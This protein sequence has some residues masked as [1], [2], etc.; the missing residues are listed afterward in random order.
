MIASPRAAAP[1][2]ERM[3]DLP[4]SEADERLEVEG[5]ALPEWL[6]GTC[7]FNG[8]AR[9]RR[10]DLAYRHWL[11]GDGAVSSLRIT[12]GERPR[13]RRRFVQSTK[14][15]DE[16]AAGRALFRTFGTAFDGDRLRR[17]LGLESPVNVSVVPFAGHLLAFG[18]QGL[19]WAL[20]P[21]TLET[22]GEHTFNGRLNAVSPLSAHPSIDPE[23][24]EMFNFGISYAARRPLVNLYRFTPDGE[25]AGR[26]RIPLPYPCSMHDFGLSRRWATFYVNPHLLDVTGIIESGQC[27]M[28]S[29]SWQPDLGSRLLVVDRESGEIA[30]DVALELPRA[31]LHHIHSFE[32]DGLLYVDLLELDEPVYGQYQPLPDLYRSVAPGRPV[33]WVVDPEKGAWIERRTLPYDAAPDFPAVDVR[34]VDGDYDDFWMLGISATGR[35][36]RKFFDQ[37][38]HLRWSDE[39]IDLWQ[40]PA[41]RL[42]ASEPIFAGQPGRPGRGLVVCHELDLGAGDASQG[43]GL[44]SSFLVFDAQ[45]IAAGP[46]THLPLSTAIPACFHAGWAPA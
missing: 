20:D 40:A 14:L 38:V 37:L 24:G 44:S 25:L 42:L 35:S 30:L 4:P 19:P 39:S 45:N 6:D 3:F 11:D 36:G 5:Q 26:R 28:D 46:I 15:R 10:G 13:F 33:R 12:R 7:Y 16:E 27:V 31:C 29:L 17:G 18:E 8:P 34:I 22:R 2:L 21:D 1:A 9:Y 32:A 23:S 43:G 41:G